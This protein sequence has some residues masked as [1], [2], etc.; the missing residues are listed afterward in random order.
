[1]SFIWISHSY[2]LFNL[3]IVSLQLFHGASSGQIIDWKHSCYTCLLLDFRSFDCCGSLNSL[4]LFVAFLDARFALLF[5]T[6]RLVAGPR[7]WLLF[8]KVS[9]G[10]FRSWSQFMTRLRRIED[11]VGLLE[12]LRLPPGIFYEIY[13]DF[14]SLRCVFNCCVKY[15]FF[16]SFV[17]I[18]FII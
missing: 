1:M 8:F 4:T 18:F 17:F 3:L 15:F 12:K 13:N 11:M 14:D 10:I 5:L 6:A 9:C 16:D 7:S 2:L